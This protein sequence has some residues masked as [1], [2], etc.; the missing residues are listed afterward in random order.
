VGKRLDVEGKRIVVAGTL[1]VIEH[2]ARLVGQELVL[3]GSRSGLRG[4]ESAGAM[5][6][7]FQVILYATQPRRSDV[8]STEN[9][10]RSEIDPRW[11]ISLTLNK[12]PIPILV[13]CC[14]G[15]VGGTAKIAIAHPNTFCRHKILLERPCRFR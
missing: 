12:N 13:N 10:M 3:R 9:I 1:R 8:T 2:P 11:R 14:K 5:L 6:A 4:S 7:D 15:R